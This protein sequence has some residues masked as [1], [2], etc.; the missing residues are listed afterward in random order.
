MRLR[1]GHK[2]P[3]MSEAFTEAP[4]VVYSPTVPDL[5]K[6]GPGI[7]DKVR[8]KQIRTR[9]RDGGGLKVLWDQRGVHGVAPDV[10]YFPTV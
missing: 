3:V 7:V 4:D 6:G 9:Y 10:V 1:S 5:A 2:V 8:D